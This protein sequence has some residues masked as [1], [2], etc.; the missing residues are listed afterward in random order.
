MGSGR[1]SM[2]DRLQQQGVLNVRKTHLLAILAL[3]V[4]STSLLGSSAL[5]QMA[6][7]PARTGVAGASPLALI[8]VAYIFKKHPRFKQMMDDMKAD[9]ERAE[10][11]V[12]NER[13]SIR[14]LAERL[15]QYHKGSPDYKAIEEDIAKRQADMAVRVQMQKREFLQ[16]EAKIYHAVYQEIQ[17]E[18]EYYAA[19][20]NISLVLRFNGDAADVE[21]PQ[22]VLR[23]IN[24]PVV[25]Y[26]RHLDITPIVLKSLE[27]RSFSAQPQPRVS[28]FGGGTTRPGVQ[29]R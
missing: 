8:D 2:E 18:V 15:E 25:Y 27:S 9:V 21:N 12:K 13:E 17:Q 16:R 10:T 4:L 28:G 26:G 20:N 29:P 22:E 3:T 23:D 1:Q 6:R 11:A 14:M 5:A 7:Q 19:S 24:K